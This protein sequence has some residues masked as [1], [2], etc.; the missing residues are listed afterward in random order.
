MR[1]YVTGGL[2]FIG[3]SVCDH[4][5]AAGHDVYSIDN[6]TSNV[7]NF[8]SGKWNADCDVEAFFHYGAH[9]PA[10]MVVHCA[11][12]VGAAGILPLQGRIASQIARDT[13]TVVDYCLQHDARLVNISTSEVYG[14]SGVYHES[15]DLRV[16]A[17][18][19]PRIEYALGKIAAESTVRL[20]PGLRSVTIRP[21]NV[22]G[23]RQSKAGGFVLPT[24]AEQA[25][26]REPLTV[27]SGGTQERCLTSVDDVARFVVML[28]PEHF[29]GRVVNI[30]NPENRTRIIDL[31]L[32]VAQH[33]GWA[34]PEILYTTGK[35]VHGAA[36]EEAE[37]V[38]KTPDV[39][40][41]RWMGWKPVVGLDELVA[42]TIEQT[43]SAAGGILVSPAG[44]V[45]IGAPAALSAAIPPPI[46]KDD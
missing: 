6:R 40:I 20:T 31:A 10:D 45:V 4:L 34:H 35:E 29:T 15:D 42:T 36:Y 8:T 19:S 27:Y 33:A 46:G 25:L 1:V 5:V 9:E 41:A 24:F 30:G 14:F 26:Q 23:P 18:L 32:R 43:H 39:T 28:E 16:P 44:D 11:S 7:V 21:F 22:A 12:P 17:T 3:S 2:G 38:V 13:Q 37:G